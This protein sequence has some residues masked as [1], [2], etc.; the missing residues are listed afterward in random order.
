MGILYTASKIQDFVMIN[1]AGICSTHRA[2]WR[3]R[4]FFPRKSELLSKLQLGRRQGSIGMPLHCCIWSV[5]NLTLET[6]S[7][8][9]DEFIVQADA[10]KIAP[11]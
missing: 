11:K 8:L 2:L 9:L 5:N 6:S 10:S 1:S 7:F 4:N 3:L